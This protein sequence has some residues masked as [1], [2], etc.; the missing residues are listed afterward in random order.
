MTYGTI[1]Q[2]FGEGIMSNQIS[3]PKSVGGEQIE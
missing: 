3:P 2:Y 1:R